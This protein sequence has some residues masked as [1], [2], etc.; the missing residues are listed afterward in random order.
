MEGREL[1]Q[2]QWLEPL[3]AGLGLAQIK[4]RWA[5]LGGSLQTDGTSTS[6]FQQ[7]GNR[8]K[9]GGAAILIR[10]LIEERTALPSGPDCSCPFYCGARSW[11]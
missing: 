11:T 3:A 7:M 5:F 8:R 6:T 2:G 10:G 4:A 9:R 1:M